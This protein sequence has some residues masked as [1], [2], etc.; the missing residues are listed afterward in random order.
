MSAA[1]VPCAPGFLVWAYVPDESL[2][3]WC[4]P[5]VCQ[6][7]LGVADGDVFCWA[8]DAHRTARALRRN[9]PGHLFAVVPADRVPKITRP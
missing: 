3:G 2:T 7:S 8:E 4:V 1:S 9:F 6:P 5:H